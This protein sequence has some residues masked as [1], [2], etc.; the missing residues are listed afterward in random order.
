MEEKWLRPAG[1]SSDVDH[2]FTHLEDVPPTYSGSAGKY[3]AVNP[4]ASGLEYTTISGI[5]DTQVFSFA[6]RESSQDYYEVSSTTWLVAAT[7]PFPG[8]DVASPTTFSIVGSRSGP[9]DI[10]Y[11]RLYDITNTV[12]I[13]VIEWT[14]VAKE[15][16]ISTDLSNLSAAAAML[17]VQ[18]TKSSNPAGKSRIHSAILK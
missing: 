16:Y 3:L 2:Y 4:V 9:T 13:L 15:I 11:C 18:V 14:S 6:L 8:T 5:E 7:F 1:H 10:S 12:E 17:E